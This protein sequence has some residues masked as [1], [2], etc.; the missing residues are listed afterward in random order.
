MLYNK[1][2]DFV[3]VAEDESIFTYEN[4]IKKKWV[5]KGTRPR[6]IQIGKKERTCVFG[7]LAE[8]KK[9]LFRQY[10]KC[11]QYYFLK[12]LKELKRKFNKMIL[13]LDLATWHKTSKEVKQYLEKYQ[14]TIIL[15]WFP[16]KWPELNPVE[17]CWKQ[18]KNSDKLGLKFH[19]NFQDFK[20][21]VTVCYRTK[22][23]KLDLYKYLCQ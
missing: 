16:P 21:S 23:F 15:K 18:G 10:P 5:K 13:Y 20:S 11:N 7:A 6:I 4:K 14:K 12:F 9:Q 8:N 2:K 3:V 22:K 19:S 1:P 17:E